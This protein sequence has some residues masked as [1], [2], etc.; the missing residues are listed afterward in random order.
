M[1]AFSVRAD[2][3]ST[4][5]ETASLSENGLRKPVQAI[6]FDFPSA[7]TFLRDD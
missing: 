5:T 3:P 6:H 7:R 2:S 1:A 4:I